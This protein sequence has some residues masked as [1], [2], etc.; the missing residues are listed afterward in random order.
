M[1]RRWLRKAVDALKTLARKVTKLLKRHQKEMRE[2]EAYRSAFLTGA[3]TLI[4]RLSGKF[5][6]V[7]D[8]ALAMYGA[9]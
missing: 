6:L 7:L 8:V 9:V 1:V 2:N 3:A 4:R 5:A